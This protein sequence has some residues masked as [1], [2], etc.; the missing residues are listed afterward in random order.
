MRVIAGRLG[1][2]VF[3][4]PHGHRTH[5]MS[6]KARGA[7]FNALGDIEG[8]G[9]LDAFAGSGAIA[10]EAIS[11]GALEAV[12]V[13]RDAAAIRTI[14]E[15]VRSLK[16]EDQVRIAGQ[17]VTSW[18]QTHTGERFAIVIADPPYDAIHLP[19][20]E[21]LLEHVEES[22]LF[23]LSWPGNAAVPAFGGFSEVKSK[24]LGDIQLVF[25]RKIQ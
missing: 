12:A 21:A 5:P 22:G 23:V 17:G 6:E 18:S 7:L 24:N 8:L 2:Q 4:S 1:G 15:N 14:R 20:L 3:A 25:Y 9:V 13:E 10:I 11:R 19:S 16:L